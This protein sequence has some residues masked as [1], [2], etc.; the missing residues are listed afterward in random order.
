MD[1]PTLESL[2]AQLQQAL[3]R[4][5]KLEAPART[6][7]FLSLREV[8]AELNRHP[9]TIWKWV[10]AGKFPPASTRYGKHNGYLSWRRSVVEDWKAGRW[11]GGWAKD[12]SSD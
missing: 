9:N 10:R 3:A 8:A 1:P 4:L 6:R 11:T 2:A 12:G 7:A 5:D